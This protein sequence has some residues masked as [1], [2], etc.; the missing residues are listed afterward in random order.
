MESE[1]RWDGSRVL[2]ATVAAGVAVAA[3]LRLAVAGMRLL[4]LAIARVPPGRPGDEFQAWTIGVGL[5]LF[6]TTFTAGWTGLIL[7]SRGH[8]RW[9][10]LAAAAWVAAPAAAALLFGLWLATPDPLSGRR[11]S[12]PLSVAGEAA[13]VGGVLASLALVFAPLVVAAVIPVRAAPGSSA[14]WRWHLVAAVLWALLA[15]GGIW[16]ALGG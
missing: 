1:R 4:G 12:T 5:T 11:P 3:G 15:V 9:L 10:G 7:R 2:L 16:F 13:L 14:G 8:R 6:L